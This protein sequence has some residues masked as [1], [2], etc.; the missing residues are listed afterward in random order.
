MFDNKNCTV[1]SI[2]ATAR[3]YAL[4]SIVSAHLLFPDTLEYTILNRF[5]T[6]GVV[7]FLIMSGYF[8]IPEKFSTIG[9]LLRKK[10]IT[11]CVPW[12]C[13]GTLTWCYKAILTPSYRTISQYINW[14]LGNGSYLYYMPVLM[15]CFLLM[16]KAPKVC[17]YIFILLNVL[18]VVLTA[19]GALAPGLK[20]LGINSNLNFFNW[21]GFFALGMLL[22][23][24]NEEKLAGFFTKYRF[25]VMAAFAVVFPVIVASQKIPAGYFSFVAI[26]Y[27]LLGAAAFFSLSTFSLNKP[28]FKLLSKYSFS[29]YLLHMAFVGFFDGL[30]SHFAVTRLLAPTVIIAATAAVLFAAS[31]VAEKIKLGKFLSLLT[32]IRK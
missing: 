24:I 19:V 31:F 27:E 25:Y 22:Q 9:A 15:L 7:M 30:M 1:S 6:I 4:F 2:F 23:E 10:F 8:F 17:K 5:G 32:G 13:L 11:V 20:L 12:F 14:I 21:I 16:Y 28:V 29:I 18:S 26:P 3:I